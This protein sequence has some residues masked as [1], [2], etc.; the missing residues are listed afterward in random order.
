MEI[1][2][3]SSVLSVRTL[4]EFWG[5][6]EQAHQKIRKAHGALWQF[7]EK[8]IESLELVGR[9]DWKITPEF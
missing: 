2:D 3:A 8:Q 1:W 4:A 6:A 5:C 9:G 7:H